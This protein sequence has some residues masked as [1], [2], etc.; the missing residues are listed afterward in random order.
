L[1]MQLTGGRTGVRALTARELALPG[2]V[3]PFDVE[4]VF[5]ERVCVVGPNGTGK[6]HVLRLLAG[7]PVAHQ[8]DWRL[9]ARVVP[10]WF[11][12]THDTPGLEGRTPVELL[13]A[14]G[15][16]RGQAIG[17]LRGYELHAAADQ[18]WQ[19]LSGGQQARLQILLLEVRGATMLLLDEPTDNLDL[20]SA[21]ALEEGLAGYQGTVL[22]VTHDRWFMRAF[23][24]FLVFDA[25]Q[26]VTEQLDPPEA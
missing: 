2:L 3:R 5:G 14:E 12:Q 11:A 24:R 21:E 9:G 10:G 4:V 18:R 6:S 20:A 16:D 19:T 22:A 25:D 23:D 1:E 13:H 15:L 7:Q 8:G 26:R 17:R